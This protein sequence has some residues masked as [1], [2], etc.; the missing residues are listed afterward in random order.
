M[1]IKN[2]GILD[3]KGINNNPLNE[4]PYSD[5]YKELAKKWS[6]FP[7]YKKANEIINAIK[8]NQ[9]ILIV[10]KTG[11]GKTV[12]VPK[13]T[14]HSFN[15]NAKIAVTLPKQI[16]AKSAAEFAAKTLDVTLGKE[17]GYQ[18][19]GSDKSGI[20][21]DN[22]LLYATDGT[23]VAR[24]L[25]DVKLQDFNC[26]IIDEAH[27]RKVQIDFLLYLLK[28][29]LV[30][31]PEFKLIIMSATINEIV[32]SSYFQDF[33]YKTFNVGGETNYPI[34]SIFLSKSLDKNTYV[35]KGIEI[36]KNIIQTND[37]SLQDPKKANDILFFVTSI[38]ET[39]NVADE[40]RKIDP[41]S[42]V[43]EVFA[44]MDSNKQKLAQERDSY[45][46]ETKKL[47]KIVIATN[48]AESS[49]TIDGIKYV[50]DS[51]FEL[52]GYYDPDKRG[53]VLDKQLITHAQAVQRMGRSGR[54]EPGVCYHLYT[55]NEFENKMKKF[56]EPTIRV[57]DIT[58][59]CLRLMNIP[60]IDTIDN[61]IGI[62]AK[63]IEPPREKY[64]RL[65]TTKM[66]QLNLIEDGKISKLGKLVANLQVDIE[67]GLA[68]I[69]AYKT[70]CIKEV[71]II[72]AMINAMKGSMSELFNLPRDLVKADENEDSDKYNRELQYIKDK[73][74][75]AIKPLQH[76]YGDHL[77]ILK[78]F[79]HFHKLM[80][81]NN[82][83]EMNKWLYDHFLKYNVLEKADKYY[84]K[85]YHTSKMI[86][87]PINSELTIQH[88]TK[89]MDYT[90]EYRIMAAIKFGYRLNNGY[91]KEKD[92]SYNT[93]FAKKVNISKESFMIFN[94]KPKKEIIYNTL[95]ISNNRADLNIVS[96]IPKKSNDVYD[97]FAY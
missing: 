30:L 12:L 77:S 49:L 95:F 52:F 1:D 32:F 64:I 79:L 70:Y 57:S 25:K 28:N 26:V 18:Y 62:L 9:V 61:L 46:I 72:I 13:Y 34:E 67:E 53:K 11:S 45:K 31:R 85:L 92:K 80:K 73:F 50:I 97:K 65:A 76:K 40:L 17:V 58:S 63:F 51:G 42:Y 37:I 5:E 47:R 44:G 88:K 20:G 35:E 41:L 2:I 84:H 71:S 54:T 59:E 66:L 6:T 10:S 89:A 4:K 82:K 39:I 90:D 27:E 81:N 22:K 14:L 38:N 74:K 29:T 7:A 56:P 19:K 91:Y 24:L 75:Q 16:I 15:Y 55:K 83:D 86:L 78:I 60:E 3:P 96:V 69:F 48:V 87:S 21:K 33:K 93:D 23:I 68:L 8:E 43:V 36:I 94:D